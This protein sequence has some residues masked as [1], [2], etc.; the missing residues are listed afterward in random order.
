ML[1]RSAQTSSKDSPQNVA[2]APA[3]YPDTPEG[4]QKQ[5]EDILLAYRAGELPPPPSFPPEHIRIGSQ[6]MAAK[7]VKKVSPDYPAAAKEQ[8]IEGTV[9]LEA[10]IARDGTVRELKVIEG[11]PAL[12]KV[13]VDAVRQWRYQPTLLGGKPVEVK[14]NIEVVFTLSR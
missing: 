4:L 8:R 1:F 12:A 9:R 14:T 5:L 7:L 6:V 13:A 3:S 11:D 2:P 10:L